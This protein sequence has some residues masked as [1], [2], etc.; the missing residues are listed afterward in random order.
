M[1]GKAINKIIS[2]YDLK[3]EVVPTAEYFIAGKLWSK[4]REVFHHGLHSKI[5]ETLARME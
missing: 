1:I 4:K 5:H 3:F 2:D